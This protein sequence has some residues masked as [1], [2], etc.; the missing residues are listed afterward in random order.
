[1]P[2]GGGGGGGAKGQI[3]RI[4]LQ[5]LRRIRQRVRNVAREAGHVQ[6]PTTSTIAQPAT[7]RKFSDYIFKPGATHG[8]DH[9][10]RSF[11]YGPEHSTQLANEF[12]R[13]ATAR[14]A[15][16]DFVLGHADQYG[17]R[18]TIP[19]DLVGQ[20]SAEGRIARIL[21]G[22]MIR[23]DGSLTLNTPFTGFAK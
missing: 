4:A 19:I 15:A 17:Q 2:S 11:G 10:F 12:T 7:V 8:K 9:V 18:I 16:R 20:G 23:P 22:W 5:F 6:M 13:Q 21:S 3:I 14:Y 1:M